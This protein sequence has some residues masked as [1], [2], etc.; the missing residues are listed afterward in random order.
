VSERTGSAESN[1]RLLRDYFDVMAK[2]GD[3]AEFFTEDVTWVNVASGEQFSG[4]TAVR[5]YIGVLHTRLFDARPEGRSLDV[6]DAHAFLEGD[7]VVTSTD[8]RVPFCLVY[9]V[10]N[11]GISAMRLY[12]SFGSLPLRVADASGERAELRE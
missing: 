2:G 8:V 3:L 12:M 1:R 5:D 7:F 10:G 9:D 11:G 4:K 6:T